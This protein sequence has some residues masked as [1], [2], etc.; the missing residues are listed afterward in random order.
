M[1]VTH[2]RHVGLL[3]PQAE[4]QARFYNEVW[5]LHLV[6][7][8]NGVYYLRAQIDEPYVLALYPATRRGI[9]H[10][11]FG[12]AD[13]AVV[14]EA[15]R[16]VTRKGVKLVQE[17]GEL[18][19][20]GGGYGFRLID[21]DGRCLEFSAE[22]ALPG[23][24]DWQAI[25]KPNKIS[26]VVLN[27]SDMRAATRFYTETLGF[28]ISD[29]SED[30]MTFLRCNTDH[31]SI[32]FNRAPHNSLNHV[33]YEVAAVDDVMRGMANLGKSGNKPIWGPG[34]HGPGNNVFCYF[35]DSAGYVAEYTCYL[36]QINDEISHQPQ[37]WKRVPE[38][39]DRW[40]T[41]GPPSLEA[42]TAMAGVPDPGIA[43]Y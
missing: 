23:Q 16:E 1:K 41:S 13:K 42:R 20:P 35:Q 9:H 14:D 2:L 21:V 7:E 15:A 22:V 18:S 25:A 6:A 24:M 17:P 11:A 5:G 34:R 10:L 28:R 33:A 26:H 39:I 38:L 37:I 3:S 40:G 12:L 19:G 30:M 43:S 29:W 8:E 32:A 4:E 31:H 36:D 27:T